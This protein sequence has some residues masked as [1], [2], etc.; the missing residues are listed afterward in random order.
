MRKSKIILIGLMSLFWIASF[1]QEKL[2]LSLDEAVEYAI[3]YNKLI[4]NADL[5]ILEAQKKINETIFSGLPQVDATIDYSNFMGAEMELSFGEGAPATIIPFNPTSNLNLTVGQ[6]IFN[7]SYIVGLQ[8]AKLYKE[9]TL[10]NFL[11]TEQDVKEQ[12]IK[13]YLLVLVS[14]R[15]I[16]I[17]E[18]NLANTREIFDKTKVMVLVGIAENLDIDQFEVQLNSLE[19]AKKSAE[20]QNE[21][22]FNILRMQLGVDVDAPLEL[23]D[24]LNGLVAICNGGTIISNPFQIEENLDYQLMLTQEQLA[25]KQ[26]ALKKMNYLPT[27]AGFYRYTEKI[28]KPELDFSPRNVIGLN[29]NVPLFSSGMRN[30]QLSQA[31]IQY[32][33]T[34]NNKA[35]VSD[36]LSLQ[37]RQYRYNLNNALEQYENRMKNVNVA[38]RVYQNYQLKY[39]QGVASSLDVATSNSNYLQAESEYIT[40]II[41]L[42]DSHLA[43][44][45]LLNSL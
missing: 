43:L 8:S 6:L 27:I 21:L 17:I 13:S 31:R 44:Q 7:G 19:N 38:Y 45:K 9:L 18:Q 2:S 22:A 14:E 37:E 32:E 34:L 23:T 4:Q 39:E 29:I 20:R 16:Q 42:F 36:Q 30:A 35:L 41:N 40:A 3:Q 24:S 11:K 10:T 33:T 1:G 25:R 28:L 5:A 26:I 15:T 12:V